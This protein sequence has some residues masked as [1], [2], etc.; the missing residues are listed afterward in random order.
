MPLGEK[1]RVSTNRIPIVTVAAK[2]GRV[3]KMTIVE[4]HR[5]ARLIRDGV[6]QNS[7]CCEFSPSSRMTRHP[8]RHL[9]NRR[10][11]YASCAGRGS[12]S[13]PS[14]RD[15][16]KRTD[17]S[18]FRRICY[19][20]R[21]PLPGF[22]NQLPLRPRLPLPL[23][24]GMETPALTLLPPPSLT[25]PLIPPLTPRLLEYDRPA[26]PDAPVDWL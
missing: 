14:A 18:V 6:S 20:L 5:F 9:G 2:A 3:K 12:G 1:W 19:L 13:K 17:E 7:A 23:P 21:L 11:G 16:A 25:E 10:F 26:L 15:S 22:E 24:S 8:S 4:R